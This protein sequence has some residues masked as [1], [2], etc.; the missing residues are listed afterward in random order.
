MA[1]EAA[2]PAAGGRAGT[3]ALSLCDKVLA[4]VMCSITCS[5]SN[6]AIALAHC[7]DSSMHGRR[8][9]GGGSGSSWASALHLDLPSHTVACATERHFAFEV[10][11]FV[12]FSSCTCCLGF[13]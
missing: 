4:A 11:F 1:L 8:G 2:V 5:S 7:T 6:C 12:I 9:G 10:L 3:A 13:S